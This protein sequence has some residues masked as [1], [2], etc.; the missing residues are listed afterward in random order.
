MRAH[1]RVIV[2]VTEARDVKAQ[3]GL[4]VDAETVGHARSAAEMSQVL[5]DM[6]RAL[7]PTHR[8]D[9]LR[10]R[11]RLG[12]LWSRMSEHRAARELLAEVLTAQ[13]SVLGDAHADVA[14]TREA[15]AG[16]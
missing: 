12:K 7:G 2:A 8:R 1:T 6:R 9:T 5:G 4:V 15:L 11:Y 14:A 13:R 10:C 16:Q 3:V